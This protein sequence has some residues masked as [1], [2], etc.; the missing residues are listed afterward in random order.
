MTM[1]PNKISNT[2]INEMSSRPNRFYLISLH[3][4]VDI[5]Y[6]ARVHYV[7]RCRAITRAHP[8]TVN[9]ES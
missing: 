4:Y 8:R 3:K 6:V 5:N 2:Q 1:L 9:A 7:A